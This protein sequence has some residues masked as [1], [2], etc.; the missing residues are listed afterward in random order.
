MADSNEL[1]TQRVTIHSLGSAL[2]NDLAN[3]EAALRTIFGITAD[4]DYSVALSG[5]TLDSENVWEIAHTTH[6]RH[7][8]FDGVRG[9]ERSSKEELTQ[10]YDWYWGGAKIFVYSTSDPDTA[11][12]L[13]ERSP[14]GKITPAGVTYLAGTLTLAADPVTD[15]QVAT[16]QYVDNNSTSAASVYA[17]VKMTSNQLVSSGSTDAI[18]WD[19][20]DLEFGGTCWAAGEPTR[21]VVPDDGDYLIQANIQGVASDLASDTTFYLTIK[22]NGNVIHDSLWGTN[23][24][25]IAASFGAVAVFI[26]LESCSED[27]YFEV[28]VTAV[29]RNHTVVDDETRFSLLKVD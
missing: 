19:D 25:D 9:T 28:F 15:N 29:D 21:L 18:E 24:Y 10:E 11:Y 7:V 5:W 8:Y 22:K 3:L 13:V 12:T 17:S 6:P 16:K 20:T 4:T 27:D 23:R 14:F 26:G 1:Q 2:D